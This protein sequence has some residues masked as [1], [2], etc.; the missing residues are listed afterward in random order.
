MRVAYAKE[1]SNH[2]TLLLHA[3]EGFKLLDKALDLTRRSSHMS[4][5][6]R[7]DKRS[8]YLSRVGISEFAQSG[9][10]EVLNV[11]I[12]FSARGCLR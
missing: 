10:V 12:L 3:I 4:D 6:I 5:Q 8:L 7:D 2:V 1:A 11:Q 9:R